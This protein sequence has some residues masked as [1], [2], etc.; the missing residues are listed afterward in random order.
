MKFGS[1]TTYQLD[2]TCN[3]NWTSLRL[4][5]VCLLSLHI[6][7]IGMAKALA[8]DD[9]SGALNSRRFLMQHFSN[10]PYTTCIPFNLWSFREVH[11]LSTPTF[12]TD[13]NREPSFQ[14]LVSASEQNRLFPLT[15]G[16]FTIIGSRSKRA[17][18]S[19]QRGDWTKQ[20]TSEETWMKKV[21]YHSRTSSF[22][23]GST[24]TRPPR[25]R[26][27]RTRK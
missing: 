5:N 3:L 2:I 25:T 19:R 11:S 1:W 24:A 15:K 7:Y 26:Q 8:H 12:Q 27:T 22:G 17:T 21:L 18:H 6:T 23:Y 14:A 13:P 20:R 9:P 4:T 16:L 10:Q